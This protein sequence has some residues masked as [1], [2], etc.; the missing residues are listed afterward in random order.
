[1]IVGNKI[2]DQVKK[3][4]HKHSIFVSFG[5]STFIVILLPN[6]SLMPYDKNFSYYSSSSGLP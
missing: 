4:N 5:Y 3:I 2:I 1:M 6:S